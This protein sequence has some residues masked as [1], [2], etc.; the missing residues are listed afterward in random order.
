M[1]RLEPSM[2]QYAFSVRFEIKDLH[3]H[4]NPNPRGQPKERISQRFG[5]GWVVR[6]TTRDMG[7]DCYIG[8]GVQRL[9]TAQDSCRFGRAWI[10]VTFQSLSGLLTY[11]SRSEEFN[12]DLDYEGEGWDKAISKN[13]HWCQEETL[14]FENAMV[15]TV[16]IRMP[17][18]PGISSQPIANFLYD[19]MIDMR[20][21]R[22]GFITFSQRLDSGWLFK[23]STIYAP[24]DILA[25]N[26]IDMRRLWHSRLV[27]WGH[28]VTEQDDFTST[29]YVDDDSD[30][31]DHHDDSDEDEDYEESGS[32]GDSDDDDVD[33]AGSREHSDEGGQD[34]EV[35][36]D[37][38]DGDE[39]QD[40]EE[41][42]D[43]SMT[44]SEVEDVQEFCNQIIRSSDA[45]G[46][47]CEGGMLADAD[48]GA[49]GEDVKSDTMD[50]DD[51]L[52][53]DTWIIAGVASS[54]WEALIFYLCTG[55]ISF[56]PLSSEAADL[57]R[58]MC[59]KAY[60]A[61]YPKRAAP[62]SAKSMYRLGVR[63]RHEELKARAFN[64]L[65]MQ[66]SE[67]TIIAEIFSEFASKFE[68]VR[69]ME[70]DILAQHWHILKN[71]KSLS[72]KIDDFADGKLPH[73][74]EVVKE[75]FRRMSMAKA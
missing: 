43:P 11:F 62:C 56:A 41:E 15:L 70:L 12:P 42:S 75:I 21:P 52:Q 14:C 63:L 66:L 7:D 1:S 37:E 68:D 28:A 67:R 57:Q 35:E 50:T 3:L 64:H 69:E 29:G 38:E 20:A 58:D 6:L 24:A 44:F 45:N 5:D 10:S 9:E 72:Q 8:I 46:A 23:P 17:V 34:E 65:K 74:G 47:A 60:K 16:E 36:V 32:D 48:D 55:I 54:T 18:A 33:M 25:A 39:E 51:R 73:A 13:L 19:A 30:F 22:L 26:G 53:Y 49:S 31:E 59:I 71:S 40:E 2:S 61:K 4:F 27:K